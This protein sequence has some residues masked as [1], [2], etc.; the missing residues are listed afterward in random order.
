MA[1]SWDSS[2]DSRIEIEN[3]R[4]HPKTVTIAALISKGDSSRTSANH[5]KMRQILRNPRNLR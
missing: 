2:F 3:S 5:G 4:K 1:G